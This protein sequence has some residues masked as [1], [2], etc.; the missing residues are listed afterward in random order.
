[1]RL[2]LA[3]SLALNLFLGGSIV[4]ALWA[5][6][7]KEDKEPPRKGQR[8]YMAA[9]ER[10]DPD[11][12][13]R[14]R[15]LLRQKADDARPRVEVLRAARR[16]A[17]AAMAAPDYNPDAVRAALERARTEE[18]ALR[19]EVDNAVIAFALTLEPEGREALAPVFRRGKDMAGA[20]G[21]G[22]ARGPR[23]PAIVP[24]TALCSTPPAGGVEI[25]SGT[26]FGPTLPE[27]RCAERGSR[28]RRQPRPE[29]G[30]LTL[31]RTVARATV[32]ARR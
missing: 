12:A 27:R 22:R 28:S 6:E 10:L 24:C 30:A 14:L 18:L 1:M 23:S 3:L 31:A 11:D 8:G 17:E 7:R 16:E 29:G 2:L 13:E 15:T 25:S 9:A 19:R 26:P 32:Q 4:G 5:G 20:A 21:G